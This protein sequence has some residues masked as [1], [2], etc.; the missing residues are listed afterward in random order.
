MS[1]RSD[2]GPNSNVIYQLLET[3]PVMPVVTWV[4][5]WEPEYVS[6]G[7]DLGY[8][9]M[10]A[11]PLDLINVYSLALQETYLH[12]LDDLAEEMTNPD[13]PEGIVIRNN[14]L[15]LIHALLWRL[16]KL[17]T[18]PEDGPRISAMLTE[19]GEQNQRDDDDG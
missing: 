8:M 16:N 17:I 2:L 10:F 1:E 19:L 6:T 12:Y 9:V 11:F 18:D 3:D 7:T 13:D 14:T 5:K 15:A 4:A